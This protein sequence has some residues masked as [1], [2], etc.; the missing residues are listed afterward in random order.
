MYKVYL[1]HK[2]SGL[3]SF[4]IPHDKTYSDMPKDHGLHG[5]GCIS[6]WIRDWQAPVTLEEAQVTQAKQKAYREK[7]EA[8]REARYKAF[9]SEV[10]LG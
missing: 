3:L 2:C 4:A 5:C 1:C 7:F 10:G 9:Q 8:E 6:G